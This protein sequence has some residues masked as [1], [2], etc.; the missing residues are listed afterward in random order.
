MAS[1]W[2]LSIALCSSLISVTE[3]RGKFIFAIQRRAMNGCWKKV[4]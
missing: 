3:S 4:A 2:A 1:S